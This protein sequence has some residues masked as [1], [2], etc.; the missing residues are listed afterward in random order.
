MITNIFKINI[1][2]SQKSGMV[3]VVN[4]VEAMTY[5]NYISPRSWLIRK[6]RPMEALSGHSK[7]KN[8]DNRQ[9]HA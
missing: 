2:A 8:Q 3:K 6:G 4:L 5:F 1:L 9:N 7:G